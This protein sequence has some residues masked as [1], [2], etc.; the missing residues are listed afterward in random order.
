MR[1]LAIVFLVAWALVLAA[2][3]DERLGRLAARRVEAPVRE[4]AFA[5]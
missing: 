1:A 5:R 4:V 2:G 3:A